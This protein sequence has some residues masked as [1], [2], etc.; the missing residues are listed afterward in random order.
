MELFFITVVVCITN[1]FTAP[2]KAGFS[3]AASEQMQ[4]D[5]ILGGLIVGGTIRVGS[6]LLWRHAN[7]ITHALGINALGYGEPLF[8]VLWLALFWEVKH[9]PGRLPD[10]RNLRH[11]RFQ[12]PHQLRSRDQPRVQIGHI[13]NVGNRRHRLFQR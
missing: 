5:V 13:G 2:I 3:L 10:H 4:M 12:H 9:C 6:S 8:G 7:Q 11:H 1:A